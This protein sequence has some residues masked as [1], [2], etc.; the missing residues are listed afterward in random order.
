MVVFFVGLFLLPTK[1]LTALTLVTDTDLATAGFYQLNWSGVP[2]GGHVELV[3]AN[4]PTFARYRVLYRGADTAKVVTGRSDG[5]Y[6]YRIR[7][8]GDSQRADQW[9]SSVK[10][11]VKHHP[12]SR[13]IAFFIIG[14]LVFVL[15]LAVIVHGNRKTINEEG[16]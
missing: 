9:S 10:V 12:L 6:F 8:I 14:A 16:Q 1:P 7:L 3:E 5:T 4:D 11:A 13:A 15:T 2:P